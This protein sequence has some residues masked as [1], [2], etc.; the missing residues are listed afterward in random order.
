MLRRGFTDRALCAVA[1]RDRQGHDEGT[2]F[3]RSTPHVD[4]AVMRLDNA[5]DQTE[6][7]AG[8]LNLGSHDIRRAIE[9]IEDPIL[10]GGGDTDAAIRNRDFDA[11]AGRGPGRDADPT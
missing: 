3:T 10:I 4:S 9:R 1:V 11:A 8:A 7:E 2:A 5:L 6:A